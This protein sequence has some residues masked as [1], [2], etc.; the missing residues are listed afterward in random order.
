M[1]RATT[2]V[3]PTFYYLIKVVNAH[4]VPGGVCGHVCRLFCKYSLSAGRDSFPSQLRLW[5]VSSASII[6]AERR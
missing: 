5:R 6:S 3:A 4:Y 1:G 2:R